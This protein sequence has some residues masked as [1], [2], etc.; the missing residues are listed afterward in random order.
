MPKRI[1]LKH[2]DQGDQE[3]EMIELE[4]GDKF[5][6]K[7]PDGTYVGTYLAVDK[8]YYNNDGIATIVADTFL[9]EEI[10]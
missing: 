4:T 9:K 5:T 2:T 1:I 3:L 6:I 7:E 8:P 10:E